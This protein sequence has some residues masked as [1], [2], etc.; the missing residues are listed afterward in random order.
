[1]NIFNKSAIE[2]IIFYIKLPKR[3]FIC[4]IKRKH[5]T[6]SSS[7]DNRTESVSVVETKNL[8]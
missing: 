2:E 5:N 1:M 3:S 7:F 4:D 6:D 8:L